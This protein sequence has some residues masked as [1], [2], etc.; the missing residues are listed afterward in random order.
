[1]K[2]HMFAFISAVALS[3]AATAQDS[4][5]LLVDGSSLTTE[6]AAPSHMEAIE[7]VYS[8]WRFR[9][10]ETQA[11]QLDDFDNPGFV[12]VDKALDAWTKVEGTAGKAC[13]SCHED[14]EDFA[15]LRTQLPRTV[16]CTRH[17]SLRS[18][19]AI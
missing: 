14:V 9:S 7:T 4:N 6:T 5:T 8:G 11:L 19:A 15:G 18:G 1:M 10:A 3:G 17:R 2:L 12:F 16:G 13:A